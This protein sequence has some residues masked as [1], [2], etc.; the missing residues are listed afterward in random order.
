MTRSSFGLLLQ[1][2]RILLNIGP[3]LF[4][5]MSGEI[6]R[7]WSDRYVE[8]DVYFQPVNALKDKGK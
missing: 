6:S 1:S 8:T 2:E 3:T 7:C 4:C 5:F